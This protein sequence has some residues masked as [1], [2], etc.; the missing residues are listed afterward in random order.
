MCLDEL[1]TMPMRVEQKNDRAAN[2]DK[3]LKSHSSIAHVFIASSFIFVYSFVRFFF[4]ILHY[5]F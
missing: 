3:L 5:S 4:F 2:D 1:N